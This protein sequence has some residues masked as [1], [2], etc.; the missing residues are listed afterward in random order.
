MR[1][2]LHFSWPG[3]FFRATERELKRAESSHSAECRFTRAKYEFTLDSSRLRFL[4]LLQHYP[5]EDSCFFPTKKPKERKAACRQFIL[6]EN[7]SSPE[8][9]RSAI[10]T[11]QPRIELSSIQPTNDITRVVSLDSGE[12][13]FTLKRPLKETAVTSCKQREQTTGK[14]G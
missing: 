14:N 8:L 7:L 13:L 10:K 1:A 12:K 9:Y 6:T 4:G 5:L 3:G 2:T 11:Q